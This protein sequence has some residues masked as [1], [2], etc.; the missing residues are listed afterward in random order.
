MS[1][2]KKNYVSLCE[3]FNELQPNL[4]KEPMMDHNTS[5]RPWCKVAVDMFTLYNRDY[6]VIVDCF[7]DY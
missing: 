4:T 5:E 7:S 1:H 6:F 2:D 3:V